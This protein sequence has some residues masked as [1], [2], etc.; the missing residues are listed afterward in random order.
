MQQTV[1]ILVAGRGEKMWPYT[2]VRNKALLPVGNRPVVAHT[3]AACQSLGV[4][5]ILVVCTGYEDALKHALRHTKGVRVLAIAESNGAADSLLKAKD[6]V[7]GTFSVLFGDVWMHERDVHALLEE[8]AYC[9]LMAPLAEPATNVI[10]CSLEN[11]HVQSFGGHHRG[12]LMTHHMAGFNADARLFPY[13]EVNPKSFTNLKVGVSSPQE[14]FVEVSLMDMMQDGQAVRALIARHP[15]FDLDKPW[16]LMAANAAYVRQA[17][18]RL[19]QNHVPAGSGIDATAVIEGFVHMG[20]QSRIGRNVV[21]KGSLILGDRSV[22]QN[23]VVVDGSAVIG[24]GCSIQNHVKIGDASV[25]G[26]DCRLDQGFELL[27]GVFFDHVYAVH[28][29][30]YF[31]CIGAH[32]DLGAGTTCGTLRFDDR[33]SAHMVKGRKE[34][35]PFYANASYMGDSTRTGVGALLMPGVKVGYGSVVGS[36]VVLN[37][38]VPDNTIVYARQELIQKKWGPEKYGW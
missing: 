29:G 8:Q 3:V 4:R 14:K 7:Q 36:G 6:C 34:I 31:G 28:F 37:Q 15:V 16:H 21:V 26:H 18:A 5:D 25:I 23:G 20:E 33:E 19:E 30:E 10:A 11:G 1:I 9:A 17:T 22:V 24:N 27:S 38:D 2:A 32:S 13:L 12:T 35:P